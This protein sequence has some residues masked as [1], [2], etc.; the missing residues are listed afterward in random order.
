MSVIALAY[1]TDNMNMTF[2]GMVGIIDPPRDGVRES[3]STLQACGVSIKMV[4][5][6]AEETALAIGEWHLFIFQL[7]LLFYCGTT[8]SLI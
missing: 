3:I 2:V 4:T 8:K 6:D 7:G 1:G 5:G